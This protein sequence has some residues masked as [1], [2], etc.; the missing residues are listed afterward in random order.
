M[1]ALQPERAA[2]RH[3]YAQEDPI[4]VHQ[5]V[6]AAPSGQAVRA[7]I[8]TTSSTACVE[9]TLR[10]RRC[11]WMRVFLFKSVRFRVHV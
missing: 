10:L 9:W 2:H 3:A 5:Q 8:A 4:Y 6:V 11:V 7:A 1:V